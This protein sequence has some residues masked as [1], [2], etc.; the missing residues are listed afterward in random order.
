[1]KHKKIILYTLSGVL[2]LSFLFGLFSFIYSSI[3]NVS[4]RSLDE[5]IAHF[6][7]EI[8]K[9]SKKKA[10]LSMW[11]NIKEVFEKFKNDHLMKMDDFS[12]FRAELQA[13][14][15]KNRLG[16][17]DISH[18][19]GLQFGGEIIKVDVNC[20]VTGTYP[21]M[22]KFIYDINK[23][24]KMIVFKKIQLTKGKSMGNS[25]GKF[26]MEVYLAR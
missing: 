10:F 22:K 9:K 12:K 17:R 11:R 16:T 3:E 26:S 21:N 23:K 19:Y 1:M 25:V 6:E 13:L 14:I 2:V 8:E 7:K 24:K 15:M 18:K 4:A 20:R 5:R